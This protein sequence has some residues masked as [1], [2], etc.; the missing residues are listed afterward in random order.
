MRRAA[1]SAVRLAGTVVILAVWLALAGL[2]SAAGQATPVPAAP[3]VPDGTAREDCRVGIALSSLSDLDVAN[4]TFDAA[5]WIWSVCP[6]GGRNPLDTM[7]FITADAIQTS[8]AGEEVVDGV[9]W[10]WLKVQGR[11]RHHWDVEQFP[12]DRQDLRIVIEESAGEASALTYTPDID[13]AIRE[14]ELRLDGWHI[15]KSRLEARTHT[16]H[17]TYGDPTDPDGTSEFS[18]LVLT[19][20]LVRDDLTGFIKLTFVVYIAF[21]VSL[22]SY[23]LNF[24]NPTMLTARLGIISGTLFAVAVSMRTGT[25]ALGSEQGLTLVDQIHVVALVAILVDALT[26]LV[27]QRLLEREQPVVRVRRF[28]MIVMALV[29]LGF[30]AMNVW[31]IARAA[32]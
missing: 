29:V 27:T 28:N 14:P 5:F 11:F 1:V 16:Y 3:L 4:K 7:D 12:F 26:A 20:T 13:G 10:S 31:L 22:I 18:Q 17:T 24:D 8:L 25:S 23:L 6:E 30:V 21:V 32:G 15:D 19:T 9:R 2:G